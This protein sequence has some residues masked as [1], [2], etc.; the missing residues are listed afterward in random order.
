MNTDTVD[1]TT[2]TPGER[3][4]GRQVETCPVCGQPGWVSRFINQ[5]GA[6]GIAVTHVM[7]FPQGELP[8]RVR[9]CNA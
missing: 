8:R 5:D 2:H 4:S 6:P 9:G 7:A 1:L 3:V